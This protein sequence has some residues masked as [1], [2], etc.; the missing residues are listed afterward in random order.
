VVNKAIYSVYKDGMAFRCVARRLARD[1]W[2]KPSEAMIRRWCTDYADGLDFEGDYQKWVVE[3]FSGVLCVDEVYQGQLALLLAVDPSVAGSDRLVGYELI[4][5]QVQRKDVERF[6]SRL[7]QAG[8]E[9][10]E[11]VTDGSPL[12]PGT[13]KEVWPEAAHQLCLFHESKLVI[14]KIYK[15]IAALRKKSLPKAPPVTQTRSLKGVPPKCP[16]PEK[17]ALH[18]VQ[19]SQGF[20]PCTTK[21]SQAGP[22]AARPATLATRSRDGFAERSQRI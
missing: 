18:T 5:G 2:V 8:I 13:L 16:L 14:G 7:K 21:E 3:E 22:S 20:W 1:F 6:L 12:Y 4:H 10:E 11:V 17:L 9:P 15:A 19:P